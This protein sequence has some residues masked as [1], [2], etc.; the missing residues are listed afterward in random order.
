[1]KSA[2]TR[3]HGE[4]LVERV[5]KALSDVS[6]VKEK[7]MFGSTA[8]MIRGKMC[9]TAREK[10]IMCR[11]APALHDAAIER[12]GCQTVVMGGRQYRG[13]VYVAAAAL[14]TGRAL[15]YWIRLALEHNQA[16]SQSR[17]RS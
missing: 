6:D 9:V 17:P 13:Y 14:K 1:M 4:S 12:P 7:R 10:R 2:A 11:I 5:R 15:K 16:Q 8:F 3:R